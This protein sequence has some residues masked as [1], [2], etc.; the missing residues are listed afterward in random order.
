MKR[1]N[2][3]KSLTLLSA[4]GMLMLAACGNGS[5]NSADTDKNG[6]NA[7]NRAID[8]NAKYD[9][10]VDVTAWRYT[11]STYKYENGD[12]IEDNIYTKTY[13]S[14]LGINLKYAWTVPI[15]QFDQKMNVS[16]AS[17]D[18]PDIMWLKNKQLTDLAE[19]DMLYDLTD[20]FEKYASPLSKKIMLQDEA[21]FNT[22][23]IGGRLMALPR[24][25]SAVDG[26]PILYV[27]TDWLDKLGLSEPKTMQEA[28]A[29]AEAFTNNDPDGNG[30]AD[31]FGLALT[32]TFLTD[33]HFGTSGYFSGYHVYPGKWVKNSSGQLEYG[34]IQPGVKKALKQ[35]QD[36][37]AAGMLDQEFGV[38][39]R[40]KVTESVAGGKVGL[41]YG[42]MSAPLSVI[43]KNVDNDP[44]AEWKALPILSSDTGPATPI[45]IMPITTYYGVSKDSKHPEAIFKLLNF[46]MQGYDEN[47]ESNSEFGI[48]ENNVPVYL[49]NL[50]AADP[51]KKNLNAH[52]NAI[53]AI[54]ANDP[55]GLSAEEKGYYERIMSYR[56]GDRTNWGTERVFGSPSSFDVIDKYVNDENYIFDAFY[57]SPTATMV[58]KNATLQKMEEEVFTKIVMGQSIDTFDKFVEDW[59]KLGGEQ[60]KK[61]INEWADKNK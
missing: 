48:S 14:D 45:G 16:I 27:R 47:A 19:N 39:D 38:K 32:K 3:I 30:K 56:S 21:S 11:E 58:E 22:A 44:N 13:A 2:K 46:G 41:F 57:G 31:T 18:L 6:A 49:Y 54:E 42:S 40:S 9:P 5:G 29:V 52:N 1:N 20:L 4:A 55:S 35:L 10:P 59:T 60:I 61:E 24:T 15:E 28:M 34:S 43:Q 53:K 36:L 8:I 50:I 12:T 26:L 17:G 37:Y 23:K 25:S 51:A 7:E 33:S